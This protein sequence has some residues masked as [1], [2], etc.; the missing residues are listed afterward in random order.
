MR[1]AFTLIELL[2]VIAIIAI[3]VAVLLP[4]LAVARRSAR[5]TAG[6]ANLRSLSQVMSA[7]THD[8]REGFLNP[9]RK[10]WPTTG[11]TAGMV[12]T[13]VHAPSDAQRRWGFAVPIC[14]AANTEGFGKVWYSYLAEYRGGRRADRE[15]ISPGDAELAVEYRTAESDIATMHGDV[16]MPTSF[17]YPPVFWSKPSRFDSH[18]RADMKAEDV[19]TALQASVTYPSAKVLLFERGDFASGR[20]AMTWFDQRAKTHVAIVD[21][22]CDTVNI[23]S[24]YNSAM[25]ASNADMIPTETCCPMPPPLP[26]FFWATYRGVQGRDLAR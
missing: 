16:L 8:N 10:E 4:A 6:F 20:T 2:V 11:A 3:L 9:F 18:C 13:M 26:T 19:E 24:L 1:R 21:G 12:W 7:Y 22:S 5:A 17:Y 25:Q 14:P 23:G 15:Q